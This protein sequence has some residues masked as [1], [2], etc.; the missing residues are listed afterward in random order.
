VVARYI[1]KTGDTGILGEEVSFIEGPEL[2]Q[3]QMEAYF[4]PV[5]SAKRLSVYEHCARAIDRSLQF[6]PHNLPCIGSGDWNDGMNEVGV[7][8]RGESVW[9]GWF[10]SITLKKFCEVAASRGDTERNSRY[11]KVRDDIG[12]AIEEHAWDGEWYRRAYFD[13]GA[14]LGSRSNDE[15]QIDSIAQSW[16]IISGAAPR[17]RA[18]QAYASALSR[19]VLED[20]KVVLLLTPP[21]DR[22]VLEPGY[23]KGYLPG[24]RENGGQ[25]THAA[26]WLVIAS[27][28]LGKGTNA[29]KIFNLINPINHTSTVDGVS[30]YKGEPYVL[31]GDVYSIRPHEGRA[32][33]SWYTGSASWLYQAGLEHILGIRIYSRFIE[34]DPCIPASWTSFRVRLNRGRYTYVIEV[35]NPDGVE[36]G[37]RLM[38]VDGVPITGTKLDLESGDREHPEISVRVVMGLGISS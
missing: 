30:R 33:W 20:Q 34:I 4:V 27:A 14:P 1:E 24:V 12:T 18:E 10:L 9:L 35:E 32:G 23:I 11:S 7:E 2:G 13:N 28:M 31:C 19:L 15:C 3:G 36:R 25:Y 22:G 16:A 37:V 6:G 38:E 8:G 5:Y 26:C 29:L 21:F 17:E